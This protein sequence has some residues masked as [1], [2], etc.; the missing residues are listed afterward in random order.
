MKN[1]IFLLFFLFGLSVFSQENYPTDYFRSPLDIPI[2][3]AG[4]FGELRSNHFH[5]GMDIKTKRR[6]GLKVYA[7]ADGYVSRIKVA[8]WGYGKV[9]YIR[10]PNGYTSVYAHLSKF[11]EGIQEY[12]KNIQYTKESYETGN[13]YP[14]ENEIIVKKGQIIG[15][16]GSTGGFVA[17]HLHYEIRDTKTEHI[18]NPMLFGLVVQDSI[19]PRINKLM[20]Y[21]IESSSR[22]NRTTKKQILALKKDTLKE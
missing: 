5:A 16:S 7:T 15:Y 8:L 1:Y 22:I 6:N 10:H 19:A 9:I 3:L 4:T 18:I 11:G 17:P 2:S 20:A 13:I 21:P 14:K 12:V